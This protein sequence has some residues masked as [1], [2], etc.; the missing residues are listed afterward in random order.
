MTVAGSKLGECEPILSS[1]K[2][3]LEQMFE[4]TESYHQVPTILQMKELRK[5]KLEIKELEWTVPIESESEKKNIE[6][7]R[8]ALEM[9]EE[10]ANHNLLPFLS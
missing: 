5:K 7:Y 6:Y 10:K 3:N 9:K 4:W 1:Y 2:V 8:K